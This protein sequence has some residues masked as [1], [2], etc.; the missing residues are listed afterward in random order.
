MNKIYFVESELYPKIQFNNESDRNEMA[1]ALWQEQVYFLWAR[2]LNWYEDGIFTGIEEDAASN[3]HTWEYKSWY[4]VP[5]QVAW[6]DEDSYAAGIAYCDEIIC[7][8]CGRIIT[9]DEVNE[10]T[11]EGI[12]P[13]IEYDRWVN[14]REKIIGDSEADFY[15]EES[16][17]E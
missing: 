5:T 10:C 15:Y 7:A 6:F 16:E 8:C 4:D 1:L 11:P 13:I 17:N 3:I 12:V 14:L 2:T 9:I